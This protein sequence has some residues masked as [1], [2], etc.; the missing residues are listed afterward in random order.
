M[1]MM[2]NDFVLDSYISDDDDWRFNGYVG[3][4]DSLEAKSDDE[5]YDLDKQ[6]KDR[7]SWSKT[8]DE[9]KQLEIELCYVQRELHIR[10]CRIS[11]VNKN[12]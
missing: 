12:E 3:D 8:P 10:Q 5:L 9:R 4:R 6:L 7:I 1:K 11:F 2:R